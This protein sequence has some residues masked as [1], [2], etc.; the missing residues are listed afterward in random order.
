MKLMNPCTAMARVSLVMGTLLLNACSDE[1]LNRAPYN[2]LS[3]DFFYTDEKSFQQGLT[4]CYDQLQKVYA[5]YYLMA[6]MPSDNAQDYGGS[7]PENRQ[8]QDL[9][10]LPNNGIVGAMWTTLYQGVYRTNELLT[11]LDEKRAGFTPA[12][13]ALIEGQAKFLRALFYFNLV[14]FW[15][16]VPLI[17]RSVTASEVVQ[18]GRAPKDKVYD[19]LIIADLQAAEQLLPASWTSTNIGRA[20][21]GSAQGILARVHLFRGTAH[22]TK[23]KEKLE[24]I[25]LS[26]QYA[27]LP[28][29]MDV[30]EDNNGFNKEMVFDVGFSGTLG[31]NEGA[32][33]PYQMDRTVEA[34]VFG[35]NG[36]GAISP[37]KNVVDALKADEPGS[38]RHANTLSP[39]G[40]NRFDTGRPMGDT[41][42]VPYIRKHFLSRNALSGT[43]ANSSQHWP[44]LRYADVLL[45]YAEVVNELSGPVSTAYDAFNRVRR[46]AN[47]VSITAPSK[48]DLAVGL[49]KEQFQ[50]A[51]LKERRYELAFEG[52][53]W[54]DL[55][56]TNTFKPVI[57]AY[58]KAEFNRT[59]N[60]NAKHFL[61]PIPLNEIQ[62]MDPQIFPQNEGY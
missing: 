18:I 1:F 3:T 43:G 27:L 46:R 58:I 9:A 44:V 53:R 10:A 26:N 57:D 55:V 7:S 56:R 16:D 6:E 60:V 42:R 28:N 29:F 21:K 15:G 52:E 61:F 30:F 14:R 62:I 38:V 47:G 41:I 22:Y 12:N 50:A 40:I 33:W 51:V 39:Y 13:V 59:G 17:N 32:A 8:I 49:S 35:R 48:V 5:D 19:E 23:A 45:M 54:F 25:M 24:A 36:N 20:T 2:N 31:A 4:G 37:S 34:G 11:K